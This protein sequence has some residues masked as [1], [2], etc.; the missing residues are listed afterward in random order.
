[1]PIVDVVLQQYPAWT[2][3]LFFLDKVDAH[4]EP[5]YE[6]F[7]PISKYLDYLSLVLG[8]KPI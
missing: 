5:S 7:F 4:V 2:A 1:M 6:I 8:I 3:W